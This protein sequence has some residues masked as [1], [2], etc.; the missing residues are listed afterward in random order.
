[1]YSNDKYSLNETISYLK[2]FN[3][4]FIFCYSEE[5]ESQIIEQRLEPLQN[6]LFSNCFEKA[7]AGWQKNI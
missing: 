2:S 3:F 1:M 6:N 7:E 4:P 5:E